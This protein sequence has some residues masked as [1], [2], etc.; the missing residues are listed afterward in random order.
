MH[1]NNYLRIFFVPFAANDRFFWQAHFVG[2]GGEH[3]RLNGPPAGH[4]RVYGNTGQKC[5]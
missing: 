2:P 3:R 4:T 5:R 1:I